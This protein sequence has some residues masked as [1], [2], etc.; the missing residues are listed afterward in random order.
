MS[1]AELYKRNS[2][3]LCAELGRVAAEEVRLR[4]VE[5]GGTLMPMQVT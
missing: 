2:S 4:L 1:R 5:I 3:T